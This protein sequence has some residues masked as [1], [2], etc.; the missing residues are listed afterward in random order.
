MPEGIVDVI[1]V[2]LVVAAIID[3]AAGP[4]PDGAGHHPGGLRLGQP[5]AL[6]AP[7]RPGPDAAS[8]STRSTTPRASRSSCPSGRSPAGAACSASSSGPRPRSTGARRSS[9]RSPCGASRR[10]GRPPSRR[11]RRRSSGPSPTSSSTAP[12]PSARRSTASTA[13]S[14]AGTRSTP[15]DQ[16]TFCFDPRVIDWSHYAPNV[17]LPSVVDH[18]RVRTTPGGRTGEKR[19]DRLRRQVLAPERHLAAFDLEN[20]LIASN[21]VA[22]YSWLATRRLPREDRV[23]FVLQTL[24]EAPGAARRSTAGP[25][26]LPAPLLPALRGRR[27]RPA[28]GRRRGDVQRPDPHQVVPRRASAGCASTGASATARCSSPAP[29][30]SSS[31]RCGRCSTTSSCPSLARRADGTYRGEL[32]DVPAHRRGPGPGADRLRRRRRLR[33][34]RVGRLRRLDLRPADARGRRLPRGRE[35]RD[36]PGRPG[37][38]AGLA[39]RAL[40]QGAGRARPPAAHRARSGVGPAAAA[41]RKVPDVK[42]LVFSR[43]PAKFAAAVVAGRL[44]PGAGAKVGPARAAR[45]RRRPSCPAPAGCGCGPAWPASAAPT[46]PPSTARRPATSSRSCRSR[47]RPA[48][49]SSATSTTAGGWCVVPVLSCVARGID[50]ACP[51]CADGRINHCERLGFGDLEPGLQSGFC[52]STGGGW[53]TAAGRPR[54]PARRRARRPDR[55]GRG[56]GRAGGLRRARR[57]PGRR[58]AGRGDRRRHARPA[59]HRR[60]AGA[61]RPDIELIATA[62]HPHQRALAAELGADVGRRP[63]R[64]RP[65]RAGPHRLDAAR[66]RPAHRRRR[67]GRRLR[68]LGRVARPGA[69]ASPPPAA[70]STSSA[71]PASPRSTSPRCGSG[72]SPCAGAYAYERAD[73][74]AALVLVAELDLGR[75]VSATYP[76]DRYE[77]AIDHAAAAGRRGAV[78]IA[79]DLRAERERANL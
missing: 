57:G 51:A 34:R 54:G 38:Q 73:F 28:R 64:A 27:R 2:D 11:R 37:P 61:A 79:F 76:L 49:R 53:S 74:D 32:T 3:A 20:T 4:V 7:R 17:H 36:P 6:P 8:P 25:Q 41:S 31:S 43:K 68:R 60:P 21:V 44:S 77:D 29:S 67:G 65:R 72:R 39:G 19:E 71:C 63:R 56:A 40:R 23:R 10:R 14:P 75:L 5:A 13:C 78:K 45:R 58:A 18:A 9:R 26:R 22:S 24:R 52:E 16:A 48:T 50:P 47:S 1:P 35:P 62:K 30:T 69:C 59:H 12:T 70:R 46:S 15:E 33:P 55:R 42:A 66:Q